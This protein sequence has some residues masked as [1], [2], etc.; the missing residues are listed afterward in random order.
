M[1]SLMYSGL[2]R[3]D[4]RL[5]PQ[6]DLAERWDASADG[7]LITFTLRSNLNWHDG[8]PLTADDV[9]YTL[10][11]LRVISPTNALLADFQERIAEVTTLATNTVQISLTERYAPILADLA[12]PI[13]PKHILVSRNIET[14]NF[15][16]AAVGSGPFKLEE[17][18][19]GAS[20]TFASNP[21][22]YRG[23][24]LLDRVVLVVAPDPEVSKQA[25]QSGDLLMA[26]FPYSETTT[27]TQTLPQQQVGQYAEN[28]YYFLAFN[29]RENR[30]FGDDRVR[31]ALAL[32]I[33]L[34]TLVAEATDGAGIPLV[35]GA[36]PG[37]WADFT[38]LPTTTVD[39]DRAR[40]LLDEAG[41]QLPEGS[42]VRQR[43]G[44]T[45]EA[46]IF[47]RGDDPRRVRAA[48]IIAEAA[49]TVGISLTVQPADFA[50]VIRSK[51]LP[52]FDF[53]LLIGSWS[54]GAGDPQ[55]ADY[56]FYDPDDFALFHE[57]QI[58]QG[59]ADTRPVLNFTG[60]N[61]S[62]YNN[63]SVAARQL[64]ETEQRSESIRRTQQRIAELKPYLFLWADRYTVALSP[65]LTTLDG[66]IN[67]NTPMYWWNI[68]RWHLR[69]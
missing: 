59:P 60:F 44:S 32:S 2:T 38:S 3:L 46:Q 57:S 30:V 26:E 66:S 11:A 56:L 12:V 8:R 22:F 5:Q 17:R 27:L 10:D 63:Q 45:L 40:T 69:K 16:E 20:I 37:S 49:R 33:D 52:P 47:V 54:G 9:Q 41:W 39:L 48:E 67:L 14:L 64:Y 53:D 24:P 34:R 13:L 55:Y 43:D 68:E 21:T 31:E 62:V 1:I 23:P 4:S 25:L 65:Q 15:W 18:M 58:N 51:Y 19:P 42:V 29:T 36:A 7:R 28:G 61:D 35:N 50:T 6:P